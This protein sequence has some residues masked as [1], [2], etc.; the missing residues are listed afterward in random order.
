MKLFRQAALAVAAVSLAGCR[1][2]E[3]SLQVRRP[4]TLEMPAVKVLAVDVFE[5]ASK[6]DAAVA[7]Y[8][9]DQFLALLNK[10]GAIKA[11]T[12]EEAKEKGTQIEAVLRGRVWADFVY[13]Q[14]LR[15]PK[16]DS[17]VTWEKTDKGIVYIAET[18]D[19]VTET[20]YEIVKAF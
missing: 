1:T 16:V 5:P 9:R 19:K 12:Y 11:V 15:E 7:R 8:V 17:D 20:T 2:P 6:D 14:G 4:P 18:R 3:V 13:E 10:E